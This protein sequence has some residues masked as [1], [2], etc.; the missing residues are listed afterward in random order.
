MMARHNLLDPWL[1]LINVGGFFF[2]AIKEDKFRVSIE[3]EVI[4]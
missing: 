3:V 1:T 4:F 2:F